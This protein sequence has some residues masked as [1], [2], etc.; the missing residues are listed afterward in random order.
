MLVDAH[1]A[2]EERDHPVRI[3]EADG[4]ILVATREHPVEQV[5]GG[6]EVDPDQPRTLSKITQTL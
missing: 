2:E 4:A 1:R 5:A 6:D 3:D